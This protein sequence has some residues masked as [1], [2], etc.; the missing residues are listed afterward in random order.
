[1][2]RCVWTL[3]HTQTEQ[4][5]REPS[6]SRMFSSLNIQFHLEKVS[7]S[8]DESGFYEDPVRKVI[9]CLGDRMYCF[10][11]ARLR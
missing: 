11:C 4:Q 1:L 8:L 5:A 6:G 10:L 9:E 3:C 2:L 7:E